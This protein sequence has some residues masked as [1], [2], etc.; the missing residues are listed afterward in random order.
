MDVEVEGVQFEDDFEIN[1]KDPDG[2]KFDRVSRYICQSDLYDMNLTLDVNT[3]IY[4]LSVGERIK[5]MLTNTLEGEQNASGEAVWEQTGTQM[6]DFEYVMHGKIFK[7]E[8]SQNVDNQQ[9]LYISFGGLL[10]LLVGDAKPLEQFK[11]DMYVYLM[12]KKLAAN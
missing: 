11:L 6:D 7:I 4:P 9:K 1:E 2:K 5:L 10:M 12:V 3:E 8:T